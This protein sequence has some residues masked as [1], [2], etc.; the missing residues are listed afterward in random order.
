MREGL[1]ASPIRNISY[2]SR[3]QLFQVIL[4][5]FGE[6][7]LRR[8]GALGY[9]VAKRVRSKW[10]TLGIGIDADSVVDVLLETCRLGIAGELTPADV[11]SRIRVLLGRMEAAEDDALALFGPEADYRASGFLAPRCA[12]A[13]CDEVNGAYW[14]ADLE[15]GDMR[16]DTER[17]IYE[18]DTH[19]LAAVDEAGFIEDATSDIEARERFWTWWLEGPVMAVTRSDEQELVQLCGV[20]VDVDVGQAPA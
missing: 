1:R 9:L 3:I 6:S 16:D 11:M 15:K 4:D 14:L 12:F 20:N 19:A 8:V 17:D 18:M 5:S 13:A 10:L 7:G 2:Q